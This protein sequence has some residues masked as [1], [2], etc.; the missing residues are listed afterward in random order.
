MIKCDWDDNKGS[1]MI[2][3]KHI[4]FVTKINNVITIYSK[5]NDPF[6]IEVMNNIDKFYN[7][8]YTELKT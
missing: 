8:L 2:N 7:D 5:Y 6:V 4:T 1:M 3:K